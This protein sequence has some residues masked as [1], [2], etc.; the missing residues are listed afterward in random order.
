MCQYSC[1]PVAAPGV[2]HDWHLVH[3]GAF[4]TGGA[5]LVMTEAAAVSPD[6]R[7]SPRDAGL[8]NDEQAEAW[9]RITSFVHRFSSSDAKIGVQL[10]HAGRKASV[11]WPFTGRSG[12]VPADDGGWTTLGP[13][14]SA[15]EG[16]AAPQAMTEADIRGVIQDF[17]DAADRAVRA[18][19]DTIE[20]H[21]AHGYLLHQ[22]QSPLVNTRT[23]AWGGD[24]EGR[25][26]LT[27][28]V[29]DAVRARIP[30]GMPLLL[31]I[32][33]SDWTEGGI[34]GDS[35]VRLARRAKEH[36]VDLVDVSTGGAVAGTR[37]PVGPGYQT[38]FAAQVRREAGIPVG[39]VGLITSA[40]QAEHIVATGQADGVFLARA[41]LRD[42]H[43]WQRAAF[44]LGYSL[45]W[46]PQYERAA[47]RSV[48]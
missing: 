2:P 30:D 9:Q 1:D 38:G 37:I 21:G 14:T 6:G 20:L 16:Y 24:E 29:I 39:A 5:A 47:A 28:E 8:W 36:G 42:P 17:A 34:D 40:V 13:T 11:Y 41:A 31:R 18:G 19:F 44:E 10:S 32:S 46:A 43:W 23:D 45:E 4:A 35:S 12:T 3:L 22:F 15:F 27:L 26:R 33:A 48:Y 25:S 7:I